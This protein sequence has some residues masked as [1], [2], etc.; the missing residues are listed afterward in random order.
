LRRSNEVIERE[1]GAAVTSSACLYEMRE[2]R[3]RF[4]AMIREVL[5]EVGC[6]NG[7]HTTMGVLVERVD[8]LF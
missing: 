4:N 5:P 2:T 6:K 1:I 3:K 8:R 7:K